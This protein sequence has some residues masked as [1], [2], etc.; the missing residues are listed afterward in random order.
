MTAVGGRSLLIVGAGGFGREVISIVRALNLVGDSW[1]LLG[2][3]D[4][5]PS[6]RALRSLA[7]SGT[8]YLGTVPEAVNNAGPAAAV[9]V[10]VGDPTTRNRIVDMLP[11]STHYPPLV[12]PETTV[13]HGVVIDSG[14][15]VAPGARLSIDVILGQ[16]VQVDQNVAVGHDTTI[17]PYSRLN[18]ASCIS[19]E[20]HLGHSVYVG[21]NATVLQRL[22]VG[23]RAVVGAGAVVVRDV[24]CAQVVK[25]VPA[26]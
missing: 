1:Q 6:E 19:G 16:H 14:C 25:G 23:A 15:I 26:S 21:A 10:A 2:V 12:H 4:D 3:A 24:A 20:V 18:P 17:G 11:P 8:Q 13:G 22:T 9:V 5:N 7:R